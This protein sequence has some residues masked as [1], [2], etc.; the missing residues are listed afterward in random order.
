MVSTKQKRI[1]KKNKNKNKNANNFWWYTCLSV[2]YNLLLK[3]IVIHTK[4]KILI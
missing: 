2:G 3:V 1:R 4:S